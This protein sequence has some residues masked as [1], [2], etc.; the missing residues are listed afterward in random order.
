MRAPERSYVVYKILGVPG[1]DG[2]QMP[3]DY[4]A[5]DHEAFVPQGF[6]TTV[7][8]ANAFRHWIAAGAP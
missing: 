5:R 4:N 6:E 8:I 3:R 2:G 1:I 7:S